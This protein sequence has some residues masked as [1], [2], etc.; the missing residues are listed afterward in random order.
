MMKRFFINVV[1]T[2]L[3]LSVFPIN[4]VFAAERYNE[5]EDA[6]VAQA[7]RWQSGAKARALISSDGKVV[8]PYGQAMPKL[9]CSPLRACDIEMEPSENVKKVSL[10]DQVNWTWDGAES[11]EKGKVVQHIVIQPRDADLETNAI[12]FTDRRTYHIKLHSPKV[13]GPYLN[14]VGFYYPDQL[15]ASWSEKMG[16]VAV[17]EA[18]EDGTNVMP[19]AVP[20]EKMAFDYVVDGDYEFK[21]LRVFNDGE[22]VFIAMPDSV[23]NGENPTLSLVD[24]NGNLQVVNYRRDVD[25]TTG[26]IHYVVSKLFDKAQL[27]KGTDKVMI[28]WK[29]KEKSFWSRES[30]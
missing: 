8:F 27:I 2:H 26:A 24:K 21:P 4:L 25:P 16:K 14:R 28:S 5:L 11:I 23:R 19:I 9:T 22:R 1:V 7:Q 13:E 12:V 17:A 15:V 18:K 6:A 30:N 29:R 20:P 3:I 10:G